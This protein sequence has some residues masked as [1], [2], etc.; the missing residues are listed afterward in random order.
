M[1]VFL[2]EGAELVI[3]CQENNNKILKIEIPII[4]ILKVINTDHGI[5]GDTITHNT[6]LA[7][8]ETKTTI[9]VPLFINDGEYIKVNTK[10]ETYIER[11]K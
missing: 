8:L 3:I 1:I 2:K 4:V 5:K 6:K 7:L 11:V 10:N 9:Q